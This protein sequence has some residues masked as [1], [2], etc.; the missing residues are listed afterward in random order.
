MIPALLIL[1]GLVAA[2]LLGATTHQ[3]LSVLRRRP[4]RTDSFFAQYTG[5]RS[6]SFT[7]AIVVLY[8]VNVVIGAVL[9]PSYR[10]NVRSP[11]E[12]M[13]V[14]WAIGLF[15][16]KEHFGGIGLGVLPLYAYTWRAEL[17]D[18]HRRGRVALTVL[19]ALIVWWNFIVGHVV[20]NIRGL[21]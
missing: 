19:L 13:S 10:L 1:H 21:P 4:G 7:T 6:Q 16:L 2:A 9:Y 20:N 17:A 12:E 18:S 14:A 15:E 11:L 5:V 3:A 8:V